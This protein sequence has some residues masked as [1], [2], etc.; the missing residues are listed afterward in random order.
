[1]VEPRRRIRRR[2]FNGGPVEILNE[3]H[4]IS[5]AMASEVNI[6]I[7]GGDAEAR[8]ALACLIHQ[9]RGPAGPFIVFSTQPE[10]NPAAARVMI[11]ASNG[12]TLFIEELAELDTDTQREL[13][14][15]VAARRAGAQAAPRR[16]I[17]ATGDN[18]QDRIAAE[19]ILGNLFYRLNSIHLVVE[20][21]V[22][23]ARTWLM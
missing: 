18:L 7:S 15:V 6:L 20:P 13:L 11:G 4:D 17:T 19:P 9:N 14:R 2:L 23:H 5:L 10:P 8:T 16:I 3:I 12:G 22:P 1:M 21:I